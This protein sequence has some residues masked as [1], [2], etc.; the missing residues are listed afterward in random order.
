MFS[1]TSDKAVTAISPLAKYSSEYDN[2]RYSK[3]NTAANAAYMSKSEKEVIYIL[4]LIRSFPAL[5]AKTVLKKYPAVSG[6]DYLNGDVY[7]F[8]SLPDTLLTL[9][10]KQML[11]PD[12]NCFISAKSHAYQSGLTG[13]VGRERKTRD[14]KMKKHYLSGC[15]D[16]G[17]KDPFGIVLSL[18]IDEGIS[19]LS[20]RLI[21]LGD[22]IKVAASVQ[23]Q[24]KY[25]TTAVMDF[26]Y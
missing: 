5:F 24:K 8:K 22:Y 3:C 17:H 2:A 18:L 16:Y 25:G 10:P 7:Y 19:K 20:H 26:Y 13:Y 4:N 12:N 1:Q 23:P 11:Y 6:Y 9:S 21:C 14:A 15:C